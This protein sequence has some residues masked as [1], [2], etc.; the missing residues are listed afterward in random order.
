M[1][2]MKING[3]VLS[4]KEMREVKGGAIVIPPEGYAPGKC[5]ICGSTTYIYDSGIYM[6]ANCGNRMT[7]EEFENELEKINE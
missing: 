2:S 6:C 4:E 7:E 1:E 5:S 3:Q